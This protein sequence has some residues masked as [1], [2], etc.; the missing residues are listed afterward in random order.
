MKP[1]LPHLRAVGLILE[2]LFAILPGPACSTKPSHMHRET[3]E[4]ELRTPILN[5]GRPQ[6]NNIP[7]TLAKDDQ[8]L[9]GSGQLLIFW[10]L[11]SMFLSK[12]PI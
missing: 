8:R 4:Q 6:R 2:T 10:G 1:A 5:V 9:Q 3:S 7:M 11:G 12:S